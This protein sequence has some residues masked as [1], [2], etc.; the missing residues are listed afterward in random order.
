MLV[1]LCLSIAFSFPFAI[2]TVFI[3]KNEEGSMTVYEQILGDWKIA[4]KAREKVK[5]DILA[6]L[7]AQIKNKQ[8]DERRTLTDEEVMKLIKKEIKMREETLVF[9]EQAK[10]DNEVAVE[11]ENIALLSVYLP[12]ILSE[13]Q[14]RQIVEEK[15]KDSDIQDLQKQR[16]LLIWVIMKEYGARVDGG[17]LHRIITSLI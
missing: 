4:F 13:S 6:Y 3:I 2:Y 12:E 7:I 16:G 17:M 10:K 11:K 15:I 5:K 8:I 9:L 1:C 14:L